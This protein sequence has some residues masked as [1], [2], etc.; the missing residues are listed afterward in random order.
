MANDKW[1]LVSKSKLNALANATKEALGLNEK[2]TLDEMTEQVGNV[3]NKIILYQS[4]MAGNVVS[5]EDDDL[6]DIKSYAFAQCMG[7]IYVR[8]RNAKTLNVGTFYNCRKLK[9]VYLD[10]VTTMYGNIF[11]ETVLLEDVYFG[12]NGVV[13]LYAG[14][15]LNSGSNANGYVRVHV[16]PEYVSEYEN[17]KNWVD[18][19]NSGQ[20]VIVGDYENE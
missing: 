20:I 4:V 2:L 18:L 10:K 6:N 5:F 12:H 19:I 16:R 17:A 1:V 8:L 9:T 14:V 13:P 3:R 11:Q 15:F 7:L